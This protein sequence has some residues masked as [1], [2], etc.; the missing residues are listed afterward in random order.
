[1]N[2]VK[3]FHVGVD[4]GQILICDPC[5]IK[6]GFNIDFKRD[7]PSDKL[8]YNGCCHASL[9]KQQAGMAGLGVCSSTGF[10]DGEYPVHIYYQH[11]RVSKIVIEFQGD[12][13]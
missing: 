9:S 2:V 4:S 12:E 13:E 5:Y 6:N 1:M 8:D 11:G 10:G 7:E 3:T